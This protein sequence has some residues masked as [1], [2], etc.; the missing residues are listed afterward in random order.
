M[1]R[2]FWGLAKIALLVGVLIVGARFIMSDDFTDFSGGESEQVVEELENL[3]ISEEGGEVE[4]VEKKAPVV[5]RNAEPV[6]NLQKTY[7]DYSNAAGMPAVFSESFS[8]MGSE[9][10]S[11]QIARMVGEPVDE[12]GNLAAHKKTFWILSELALRGINVDAP[13]SV[14]GAEVSVDNGKLSVNLDDVSSGGSMVLP[15]AGMNYGGPVVSSIAPVQEMPQMSVKRR[16]MRSINWTAVV[17][18]GQNY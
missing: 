6:T 2:I 17:E 11:A 13:M 7:V 8:V 15:S 12:W 1:K 9:S 5:V 18:A 16:S 3:E 10:L 4:M 14:S